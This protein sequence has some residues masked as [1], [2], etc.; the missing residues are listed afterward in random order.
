MINLKSYLKN[1]CEYDNL[2]KSI[3]LIMLNLVFW[4]IVFI[5]I[6]ISYFAAA[7]I[8]HYD[9]IHDHHLAFFLYLSGMA[10]NGILPGIDFYSPH[11]VFIP[12]ITGIFLKIFGINQINLSI[13]IGICV[14]ITYIFVYKTARFVM[15][16]VFAKFA[17]AIL[18]LT[19][20]GR[21]LPWFNDVIM[22]FVAM[23][24][25]FLASYIND[26]KRY[27]LIVLGV[28]C[29]ILPYLRQQGLIMVFCFFILPMVLYYIKAIPE[30]AY[31]SMI[32]NI[33]LSF[34]SANILFILFILFRN[35]FEGL[36]ILNSSLTHLVG[37]AQPSFQ[38]NA[39][40]KKVLFSILNYTEN[41]SDWHNGSFM[42]FLSYWF[43]VILPCFYYI[44]RPFR[45]YFTKEVIL[46]SDSIK[47]IAATLT[48]STII[49]NYPINEE[50]R[51][52]VQFGIGI[53]LFVDAL[54]ILFY[55]KRIKTFSIITIAIVCL[56]INYLKLV[57][58][59]DKL[60][61]NYFNVLIST[62]IN[63]IRMDKDTP[64]ANSILKE[65]RAHYLISL[66][67]SLK[68]YEEKHPNKKIIFDGELES[69][70]QFLALLFTKDNVVLAHKFPYYYEFYDRKSFMPDIKE[71][72][73]KF[74][75]ENKPII[76]GCDDTP[77]VEDYVVLKELNKKCR[78]LVPNE[79]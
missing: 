10:A 30:S 40:L 8:F 73:I 74:V 21:D 62:R 35:G 22:L 61:I 17:I 66:V 75:N 51:I 78:I 20:Q 76:I 70:N 38:Y 79:S 23:G 32:K 27:K 19:Q 15:P 45:L 77:K 64:Y 39:D 71:K 63:H 29:F 36:E 54:M 48:L 50:A 56:S 47:M 72:F 57:Q 65:D 6:Y 43:I 26:K 9:E 5:V 55:D 28:I 52:R 58:F 14:F 12:L 59:L 11:S 2:A 3:F 1:L 34:I 46:N 33:V 7:N 13:S 44:Y 49:F 18:L 16:N 68:E 24:I 67:D 69:I 41:G 31:K 25:Y 37:M 53:W 42:R 60:A 4:I